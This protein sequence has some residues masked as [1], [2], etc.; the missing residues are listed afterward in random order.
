MSGSNNNCRFIANAYR[1]S[2]I[3]YLFEVRDG[4]LRYLLYNAGWGKWKALEPAN[5]KGASLAGPVGAR[6]LKSGVVVVAALG[7][8]GN[9]YTVEI[10]A[11]GTP[12]WENRGTPPHG[13]ELAGDLTVG[14]WRTDA[15]A[16]YGFDTAG[17]LWQMYKGAWST[18]D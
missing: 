1:T 10:A 3:Y 16:V 9:L 8:D 11:T 12:S 17:A 14:S 13:V 15:F 2:G 7:Q 6:H 4:Q 5:P 18:V